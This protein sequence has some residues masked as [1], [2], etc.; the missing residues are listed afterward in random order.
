[1][2]DCLKL[3]R[4]HHISARLTLHKLHVKTGAPVGAILARAAIADTSYGHVAPRPSAFSFRVTWLYP[5]DITGKRWCPNFSISTHTTIWQLLFPLHRLLQHDDQIDKDICG[6]WSHPVEI[7]AST[8]NHVW[9]IVDNDSVLWAREH[10]D[11]QQQALERFQKRWAPFS[12]TL[13]FALIISRSNT[14]AKN[15]V[16]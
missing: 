11:I 16:G 4:S 1:M 12:G 8:A 5:M 7:T 3:A 6:F 10:C 15:R 13:T 14:G 2:T 9:P